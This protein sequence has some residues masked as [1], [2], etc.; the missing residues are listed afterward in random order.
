MPKMTL[1][2]MTQNILSALDSDNVNSITDTEESEQV[3]EI[4][5]ETYYALIDELH[6]PASGTTFK[7]EATSSSTPMKMKIPDLIEKIEWVRY[8]HETT[9][10]PDAEY[11]KINYLDPDD[12][13]EHCNQRAESSDNITLYSDGVDFLIK[14]DAHPQYY[15]SFDDVYLYFDSYNSA[16]ETNLQESRSQC[17][18]LINSSWTH[19]DLAIPSLPVNLFSLLLAEAKSQ[20]FI[21]LKQMPNQKEEQKARRQRIA[22]RKSKW[23]TD[24]GIKTPN[25]GRKK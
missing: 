23:K 8:N 3:A 15:T 18:G 24:G 14:T 6:L 1:L 20:S 5:K 10:A 4:V 11:K 25:Y 9:D 16:E 21:N 13:I 17:Y 19:T 22:L 12:F 7:L 2:D